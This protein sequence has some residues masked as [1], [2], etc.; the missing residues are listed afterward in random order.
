MLPIAKYNTGLGAKQSS[1]NAVFLEVARNIEK[2]VPLKR[3]EELEREAVR[4]IKEFVGSSRVAYG[5][6]G[7]K[8]S[9]ALQGVCEAAGIQ[10][11]VYVKTYLEFPEF[12]DWVTAN[13]PQGLTVITQPYDLEWLSKNLS[14]LFPQD[15]ATAGKWFQR[16]QGAG[17]KQ[18]CKEQGLKKY[19]LGRRKS[20]RNFV[21][22]DGLNRYEGNGVV[23]LSPLANWTHEEVIAYNH[24]RKMPIPPIYS[25]PNGFVVGTGPWP[26]RQWTGS[27]ENGW[28]E[29]FQIDPSVVEQAATKI[30]S[31]RAF[32]RGLRS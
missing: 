8:D 7:G 25:W 18:Y 19:I 10:E 20:D 27:I 4:E 31:A 22:K 9:M 21:G 28:A 26:A 3:I 1:S 32:L 12:L 16:V 17:R 30:A 14:A 13:M 6:S 5:W 15:S 24:F 11:C 2:I 29:T 23:H